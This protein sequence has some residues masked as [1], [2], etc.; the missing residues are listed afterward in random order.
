MALRAVLDHPKLF[1]LKTLLKCPRFAALGCLESIWHFTGRYTPQGDIGKYPDAAIET[2]CEWNGKPGSLIAALIQSG[3]LDRSEEHRILVHDWS[4]HADKATK[5]SIQRAG[6]TFYCQ[7]VR[8][9]TYKSV[10]STDFVGLPEPVPVPVPEPVK[11][12]AP[13]EILPEWINVP[14]WEG[15]VEMRKK[16]K[17]PFT[18]LARKCSLADLAK[19]KGMGKDPNARLE[20]A[21]KNGWKGLIFDDDKPSLVQ[22]LKPPGIKIAICLQA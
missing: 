5:N 1:T 11:A 8:T 14:L 3:W 7:P 22:Q 16:A 18:D 20:K 10:L 13:A 17:S 9:C 4:E 6:L 19:L 12:Q 2:W 21:I 15:W